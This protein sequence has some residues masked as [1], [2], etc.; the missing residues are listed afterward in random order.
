MEQMAKK[1]EDGIKS[2]AMSSR[3]KEW[4]NDGKFD[5]GRSGTTSRAQHSRSTT[6]SAALGGC[7]P[8][9]GRGS[10]IVLQP[11]NR[12]TNRATGRQGPSTF[13]RA[14]S[15]EGKIKKKKKK[16]FLFSM[17]MSFCHFE[18][19]EK[20]LSY[21]LPFLLLIS[22]FFPFCFF[23]LVFFFFFSFLSFSVFLFLSCYAGRLG[24]LELSKE[25]RFY[26]LF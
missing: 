4:T 25:A 16:V 7:A 13:S 8:G 24:N 17:L 1:E 14:K 2:G 20:G 3:A 26:P 15:V 5:N 12:R 18:N 10:A 9:T 6:H 23:C 21:K 22:S 11:R 19:Q